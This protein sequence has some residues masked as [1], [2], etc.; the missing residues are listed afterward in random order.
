VSAFTDGTWAVLI[1]GNS[2]DILVVGLGATSGVDTAIH[3]ARVLNWL[4]VPY[5]RRNG[6]TSVSKPGVARIL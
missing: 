6:L 4:I 5:P 1:S 2:R 3:Q